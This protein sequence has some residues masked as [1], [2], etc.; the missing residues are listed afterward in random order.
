[1]RVSTSLSSDVLARLGS[2]APALVWTRTAL[3]FE[4]LELGRVPKPGQSRRLALPG[5]GF[6][7]ENK[8]ILHIHHTKPMVLLVT[9]G[10]DTS[11]F[12]A[13]SQ[14]CHACQLMCVVHCE[15]IGLWAGWVT[16]TNQEVGTYRGDDIIIIICKCTWRW[17]S[18]YCGTVRWLAAVVA[19][20]MPLSPVH[21]TSVLHGVRVYNT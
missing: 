18:T 14:T 6:W 5:D 8:N 19:M 9:K 12:P 17:R 4:I 2:K 15:V 21:G 16:T 10:L 3:T 20:T 1:L 7:K 13:T 11:A